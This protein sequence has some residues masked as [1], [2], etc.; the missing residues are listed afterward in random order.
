M[1]YLVV[2]RARSETMKF[3][4]LIS[5]YGIRARIVNTPRQITVACGISAKIEATALEIAKNIINRRQFYTFAGIYKVENDN[6]M[7]V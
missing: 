2:F 7:A 4:S 1:S 5:S 6:Y 3:A